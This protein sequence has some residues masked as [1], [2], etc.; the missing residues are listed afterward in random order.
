[1]M[2][3]LTLAKEK[4]QEEKRA[5]ILSNLPVSSI[6]TYLFFICL[7]AP[8][9]TA[10]EEL[11][12]KASGMSGAVETQ[13]DKKSSESKGKKSRSTRIDDDDDILLAKKRKR[14]DC[15]LFLLLCLL[16][17]TGFFL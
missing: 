13:E 10:E 5:R 14:M 4:S 12:N 9:G 8:E 15:F 6:L 17:S 3:A 16:Y 11:Q 1:M 2:S 7:A